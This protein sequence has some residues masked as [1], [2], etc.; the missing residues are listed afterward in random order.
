MSKQKSIQQFFKPLATKRSAEVSPQQK[1]FKSEENNEDAVDERPNEELKKLCNDYQILDPDMGESWFN[2]LKA[3]FVK[4]YFKNLSDFVMNERKTHKIY[5]GHDDVW[6]WTKYCSLRD[7]KVVMIGQDP[8]HNPRQAH[9]LC[10][11]VQKG[12]TP[13]PSLVNMFKELATDVEGFKH[14]GHGNLTEWARQG[15]LLLNACLTVRENDPNSHAGKGWEKITDA[16]IKVI[17][18]RNHGVVFLLWGAFAQKK[19]ICVDKVSFVGTVFFQLFSE[20]LH[21]F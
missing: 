4:P 3:E 19:A 10:F 17:S 2:A 12:V 7:V 18:D 11:S 14:P 1:R 16:V 13:P 21:F 8:Y 6:S 9:G 15:V 20:V 5:P